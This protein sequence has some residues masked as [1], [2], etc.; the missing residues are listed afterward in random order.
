MDYVD[1]DEVAE[2]Q[3]QKAESENFIREFI[4]RLPKSRALLANLSLCMSD[5]SESWMYYVPALVTL[6]MASGQES[7]DLLLTFWI[8][9]ELESTKKE[10]GL[11][12]EDSICNQGLQYYLTTHIHRWFRTSIFRPVLRKV[13]S[14]QVKGS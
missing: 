12:R 8:D 3:K 9:V 14:G 1:E 11:F 4:V 6:F 7:E 13:V 5:A 10:T 2:I